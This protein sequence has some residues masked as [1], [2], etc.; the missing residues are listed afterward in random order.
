VSSDERNF[1]SFLIF[2]PIR[3]TGFLLAPLLELVPLD[4]ALEGVKGVRWLGGLLI[5]I[6]DLEEGFLDTLRG[7]STFD[8]RDTGR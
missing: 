8:E 7:S 4:Y 2:S 6:G 3:D 1:L 5:S